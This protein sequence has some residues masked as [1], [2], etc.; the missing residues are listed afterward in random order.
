[1]SK[2]HKM[3]QNI[4]LER[5][6]TKAGKVEEQFELLKLGVFKVEKS[7]LL[8]ISNHSLRPSNEI[9]ELVRLKPSSKYQPHYHKQ[10]SA[11]IYIILGEGFFLSGKNEISYQ[12]GMR[13]DL[14]EKTPHGFL[15]NTETLFLSIQTP[16]ILNYQTGVMDLYYVE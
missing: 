11:V 8:T 14:P 16:P 3:L 13:F 12:P 10:S 6:Y 2:I 15:T 4:P 5:V 9:V 1:M 7:I